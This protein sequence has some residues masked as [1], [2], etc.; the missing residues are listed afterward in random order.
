MSEEIDFNKLAVELVNKNMESFLNTGKGVLKGARDK[1][2]L[3]LHRSYKDYL[4]CVT[5]RYSKAKSFFIRDEPTYLYNFYVPMGISSKGASI[6]SASIGR[7]S[8]VNPF[9]VITGTGGSGKSMLMR[10]LF[11]DTI[12]EL[13]KVPV[14]LELRELNNSDQSLTSLIQNTL[15]S[16]HFDLDNDYIE[17]AMRSGHFAF[18][19][20]GFDE[21][22]EGRRSEVSKQIV[23]LAQNYDDN[24][25][26]VSSR[27]DEEFSRWAPFNVFAI[28]ELTLDQATELVE[29]LPFESDVK[30][31]FTKDLHQRLFRQHKSFL[32][33]PL[34]LSIMLLTSR[35][36]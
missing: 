7:I 2:R 32:S 14:F 5:T 6:K 24:L 36:Q 28:D 22:A 9:A 30:T 34:L 31:K 13:K 29:K 20:D 33:N 35:F 16:N 27:P 21:I 25:I 3:H 10:H 1:I 23:R 8:R 12:R 4:S 17:K 26:I 11:L 18:L 19:L 15:H